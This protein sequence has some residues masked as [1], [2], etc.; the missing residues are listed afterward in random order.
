MLLLLLA[1]LAA[2]L[3]A[4]P[5]LLIAGASDMAALEQP[6]TK[7]FTAKNAA[8]LRWTLGSSGTLARQI[9]NGA[10]FDVYLSANE[11]Y[12]RDLAAANK[13]DPATVAIYAT[14]RLG[15]WS[16]GNKI[17]S[18]G[19]L[20]GAMHIAI[21]NPAH[22]PYGAAAKELLQREG[23]WTSLE[24]K[25]VYGEN[26]R[27]AWQFGESGNADAVLTAWSLVKDK[28][29]I[30]VPNDKHAAIRQAAGVVRTSKNAEL[31]KA[32]VTFLQSPEGFKILEAGGL[33]SPEP[34]PASTAT[35]K[36]AETSKSTEAAKKDTTSTSK[37]KKSRRY[38]K[39]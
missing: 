21:A 2:P 28:G 36:P 10:P 37:K 35:A 6:I 1:L 3:C 15:L 33:F 24:P 39:H 31:A 26:V 34:P 14:G 18:V 32:F 23:L 4:Q 9:E 30:L 27:Q 25:L 22:A 19:Q 11:K 8:K 16:N 20:P 12:V 29:A 13:I 17:Q 5:E 7:A 38:R